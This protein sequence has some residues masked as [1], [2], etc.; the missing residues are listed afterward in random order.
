MTDPLVS[1]HL[2]SYNQITYIDEAI[3]SAVEQD[4]GDLEVLCCDDG[5]SDGTAD[6]I[7]EWAVR[8]PGRVI[9][10]LG[11]HVGITA[12]CNRVFA[13]IR[14]KYVFCLAGDDLYL[15]GKI[16]KQVD[17]FEEDDRRVMCGHAAEAF[18]AA[19]GNPLYI[20]TDHR[21]L[22]SGCGAKRYLE[23]F[24]LFPDIS[25]AIRRSAYPPYG[26]DERA[27][28]VSVF[29]LN[30]DILASGGAYGYVEGLFAR[31]RVHPDSISVR[32][33]S[34]PEMHRAF[35]EG[36]LTALAI[37]EANHPHLISSCRKARARL[38]FSEGRWHQDRHA[39]A[40]ARRYFAAA[41]RDNPA[42]AFKA[43][44]ASALTCLPHALGDQ[45]MLRRGSN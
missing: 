33:T 41:A 24:G 35:L 29:K 12:N 14:G 22:I 32:S 40:A 5:S 23:D 1:V 39:G 18:E 9:P 3:R 37:T 42:L 15:P 28:P 30:I 21:A 45:I 43:A 8:Y 2:V 13:H 16:R 19:T 31:Y 10:V 27:G 34:D 38:L 44:A 36:Y 11:P 7:R 26:Y 25:T 6:R 20:T 17:W 4:Y